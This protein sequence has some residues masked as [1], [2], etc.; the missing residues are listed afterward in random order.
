MA[1]LT[2]RIT[3][4]DAKRHLPDNVIRLDERRERRDVPRWL[5]W[6]R[7]NQSASVKDLTGYIGSGPDAA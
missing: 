2:E 6:T 1:T 4:I 3:R 7:E 5:E